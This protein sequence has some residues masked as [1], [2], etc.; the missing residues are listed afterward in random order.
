MRS[1]IYTVL[2]A[3]LGLSSVRLAV[4]TEYPIP[5]GNTA[6]VGEDKTVVTVYEDTLYDLAASTAWA[7]RS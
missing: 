6:V 7:P 5:A 4:A 1:P 3:V 2:A